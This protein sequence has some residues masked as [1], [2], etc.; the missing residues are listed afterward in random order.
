MTLAEELATIGTNGAS[1]RT[2][3]FVGMSG[4]LA[5]V[6]VADVTLDLPMVGAA[7]L[8]P[9]DVVQ[10]LWAG[11]E[12]VVLGPAVARPSF[13]RV[14]AVDPPYAVVRV[15]LN[16]EDTDYTLPYRVGSAPVMGDLVEISWAS[17]V[18]AGSVSAEPIPVTVPPAPPLPPEPVELTVRASGSWEWDDGWT[19]GDLTTPGTGIW[20][21]RGREGLLDG[22]AVESIDIFMP[23]LIPGTVQVGT[24]TIIGTPSGEPELENLI[25]ITEPG[26]VPL[27]LAAVD[28]ALDG[29]FGITGTTETAWAGVSSD[30]SSGQIRLR[31]TT[32]RSY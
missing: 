9:G 2:G 20:T 13:G 25:T 28:A 29:G 14:L 30:P 21:Y 22:V 16:G 8:R 5:Q 10:L 11:G 26:W 27:P 24:H 4:V 15:S 23:A 7:I 18:I 6:R 12:G 3:L 31:G 19:P 1:L 17:G 32:E